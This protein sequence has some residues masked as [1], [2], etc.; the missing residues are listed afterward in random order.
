MST[1]GRNRSG[2]VARQDRA[3]LSYRHAR[4]S[5][6][7]ACAIC[8]RVS[9]D[10]VALSGGVFMNRL[11]LQLLYPRAQ[12]RGAHRPAPAHH[13]R[14]RRLHCLRAGR[15]RACS[16]RTGRIALNRRPISPG[17]TINRPPNTSDAGRHTGVTR[18]LAAPFE[19]YHQTM[20]Y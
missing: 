12:R 13:T 7:I 8:A 18:L 6:R 2:R 9:L 3:R 19:R 16:S 4:A 17:T 1:F 14:Q 20:V 11:L 10:T 15:Y 5:A